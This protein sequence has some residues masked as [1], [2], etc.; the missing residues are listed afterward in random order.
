MQQ[1]ETEVYL[2]DKAHEQVFDYCDAL[3]A[4]YAIVCNG[5]GMYCYK[6][7]AEKDI[8]EELNV[9]HKYREMLD[10]QAE[11]KPREEITVYVC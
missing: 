11:I 1:G 3:G 4:D 2:D 10:G 9:I 6:Y 8:Y 5:Y 7:L